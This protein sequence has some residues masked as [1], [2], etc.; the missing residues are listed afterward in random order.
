MTMI[1]NFGVLLD[2]AAHEIAARFAAVISRAPPAQ[3]GFRC[4]FI[5]PPA[6]RQENDCRQQIVRAERRQQCRRRHFRHAE[7]HFERSSIVTGGPA[8]YLQS[9]RYAECTNGGSDESKQ[10]IPHS[11]GPIPSSEPPDSN[12][13]ILGGIEMLT[14]TG[15]I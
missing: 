8:K 2:K 10:M 15:I 14:R 4:S 1:A 5:A 3:S 7:F 6:C 11:S 9:N 13:I 12:P